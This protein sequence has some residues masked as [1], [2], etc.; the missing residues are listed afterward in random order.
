MNINKG[1]IYIDSLLEPIE[2]TTKPTIDHT[3]LIQNLTECS[4]LEDIAIYI[5]WQST[6]S[7]LKTLLK[8]L[9]SNQIMTKSGQLFRIDVLE[10]R[11]GKLLKLESKTGIDM[12]KKAIESGDA[13]K[14]SCGN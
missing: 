14:T 5:N 11:P 1:I 8:D 3:N 4:C 13:L 12:L 6:T 7:E 10:I 2:S 9:N